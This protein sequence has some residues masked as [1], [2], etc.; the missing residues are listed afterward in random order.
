ME[1]HVHFTHHSQGG[2]PIRP[3]LY[4]DVNI[5]PGR[6]ERISV[7]EWDSP[8]DLA[9]RFATMHGLPLEMRLKLERMLNQQIA[10]MR[11]KK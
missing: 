11:I 3:L 5:C 9:L 1:S 4:V 10:E 7:F 6:S 2:P 8:H